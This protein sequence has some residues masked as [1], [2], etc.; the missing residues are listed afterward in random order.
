MK[1]QFTEQIFDCCSNENFDENNSGVKSGHWI[2]K[3]SKR[4]GNPIFKTQ[5]WSSW[6]GI[7]QQKGTQVKEKS[8]SH[9][10]IRNGPNTA[11]TVPDEW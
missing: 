3:Y 7:G 5:Y 4:G 1:G 8:R 6:C 2:G 9:L 11:F 10:Q